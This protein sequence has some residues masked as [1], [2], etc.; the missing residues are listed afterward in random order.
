MKPGLFLW[1]LLLSPFLP[2]SGHAAEI[3]DALRL[4]PDNPRYFLF[5]GRPTILL[6]SGEH[7]GAVLNRAFDF[8]RYLATLGAARLNSTRLFTGATYLEPAGAFNIASNTLAPA[9]GELI[10]PWARSDRPGF[11]G[12]GNKFDLY[13]WDPAWFERL[14]RFMAAAS[15]NGVVV[16]LNLFCPFY[17]EKQ[18][19]LSPFHPANNINATSATVARTNVHTLDRHE[20]LLAIQERYVRE[21]VGA[22]KAY[23]NLYYEICNEPYFGGITIPWQHRIADVITEAQKDHPPRQRKLISQNI[24]NGA[25]RVE[26]PHPNVAILNFHYATPPDA[27]AQNS[28][29]GRVIGD[30]ETGF[31]G[32]NDAP[33]R[34]EAWD[35]ILAGGGLFNH[36][37]YS[38]TVGHEDGTFVYPASQPGGGNPA[39]RRQLG[40]LR[41][42]IHGLDFIRLQ[43]DPAFLGG[44]P[45]PNG[46][47][48]RALAWPGEQYAV[49]L[50]VRD[51]PKTGHPPEIPEGQV[52]L[53]AHLPVGRYSSAWIDTLTGDVLRVGLHV[54]TDRDQPVPLS[55]PRFTTDIAFSLRQA[56][57]V[58]R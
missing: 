35:F 50:R 51:L 25:A 33:Y 2:C 58:E 5:R 22:L 43:P 42:F 57:S 30:N 45:L 20:G 11:A 55:A 1:L 34:L 41:D 53:Q 23:D 16:E 9:P 36:L 40:V 8:E 6:T 32:T 27:V 54:V 47:T 15:R 12:G 29:L 10:A 44:S 52:T 21:I 18:W 24:A 31:R 48:A 14:H 17:E 56:L 4:H 37:D 19:L 3:S 28:H 39:F 46:L 26:N 13:R 7:Y 38:F 49:Y